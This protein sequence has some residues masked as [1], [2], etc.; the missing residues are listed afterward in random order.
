MKGPLRKIAVGE[1][2]YLFGDKI[3]YCGVVTTADEL[4]HV[5]WIW[6]KYKQRRAYKAVPHWMFEMDWEY[7]RKKKRQ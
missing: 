7:M 2:F 3:H 4:I 5:Y 1:T 6:N